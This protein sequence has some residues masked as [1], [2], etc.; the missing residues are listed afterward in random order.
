MP[1]QS[2]VSKLFGLLLILLC[3][4]TATQ[5]CHATMAMPPDVADIAGTGN[6]VILTYNRDLKGRIACF[7]INNGKIRWQRLKKQIIWANTLTSGS[8]VYISSDSILD[9]K[10]GSIRKQ[11]SY[12]ESPE[13][14]A[15]SRDLIVTSST[16]DY[17]DQLLVA[18]EKTHFRKVWKSRLKSCRIVKIIPRGSQFDVLTVAPLYFPAKKESDYQEGVAY[19]SVDA[20]ISYPRSQAAADDVSEKSPYDGSYRIIA[21]RASDGKIIQSKAVKNF[22]DLY[23]GDPMF[24]EDDTYLPGTLPATIKS[25]IRKMS[26]TL[27][28]S[29]YPMDRTRLEHNGNLW[30]VGKIN[31]ETQKGTVFALDGETGKT[32]WKRDVPGLEEILLHKG[33]LVAASFMRY[34]YEPTKSSKKNK[35]VALDAK[36]GKVCWSTVVAD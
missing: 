23:H 31:R 14:V 35:L 3:T 36:T 13:K 10:D 5:M 34:Q 24:G 18:Y 4:V 12:S 27:G 8:L 7:D 22:G 32:V 33:K 30:F 11:F 26:G 19:A 2:S 17:T 25:F 9:L 21:I 20:F 16:L 15:F 28:Y 29:H 1:R 6:S